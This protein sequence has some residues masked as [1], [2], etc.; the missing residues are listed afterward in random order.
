[1]NTTTFQKWVEEFYDGRGWSHYDPFIRVG[2]LMEE[3]GEVARVVRAIEIGRDRPDEKRM[4]ED[5]L[6]EELTE[7]LGDVLANLIIL[8]EKYD[9]DLEEI[10]NHH[11]QKL[12]KRFTEEQV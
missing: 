7:E 8:A 4:S 11:V 10:M 12:T 5:V 3:V 1:M 9:I 2:F 6:K